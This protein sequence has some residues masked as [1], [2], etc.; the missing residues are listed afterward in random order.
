MPLKESIE[1]KDSS[2][3]LNQKIIKE[4]GIITSHK[5]FKC[6][7]ENKESIDI[8]H[9]DI[10]NPQK[11][12]V[13]S[14][15]DAIGG[16][17]DPRSIPYISKLFNHQDKELRNAVISSAG[18]IENESIKDI[19]IKL[20]KLRH[21][22]DLRIAILNSLSIKYSKDTE[23]NNLIK[24]FVSSTV[25][26]DYTKSQAI[27]LLLKTDPDIELKNL[28]PDIRIGTQLF[29]S[30]L[31]RLDGDNRNAEWII[32]IA[33]QNINRLSVTEKK[34][35]PRI[36]APFKTTNSLRLLVELLMDIDPE[37][38]RSCYEIIGTDSNQSESFG[39]I[40]EFMIDSA[41]PDP[42]LE[43]SARNAILRIGE[44][45]YKN[46]SQRLQGKIGKN[47]EELY[48]TIRESSNRVLSDTHELG[49]YIVHSKEYL[50]Y[51]GNED[52]KQAIVNYL[53]GSG[54]YTQQELLREVKATAVKVEVRHFEG[55]NAILD[56]IK[57]PKRHGIALIARELALA[58][59]G[60]IR[61]MY[62]LIRNLYCTT[63]FNA[64]NMAGEISK[65]YE[66]SRRQ[67]LFRLAEAA[68]YALT[69]IDSKVVF[70]SIKENITPP[71]LSK[72]LAIASL[73]LV[74]H[75]NWSDIED[76]LIRLLEETNESYII[77]NIIDCIYQAPNLKTT[78]KLSILNKFIYEKDS[79]I[80][81]RLAGILELHIDH[82]VLEGL[83]KFYPSSTND[84]K[85]EILKIINHSLKNS[86]IKNEPEITEF[87]YKI[88]RENETWLKG[89]SAGILYILNDD[90]SYKAI[91]KIISENDIENMVSLI[92]AIGNSFRPDLIPTV[93]PIFFLNNPEI[94]TE[95]RTYIDSFDKNAGKE[96]NRIVIDL[97]KRKIDE[98]DLI[99]LKDK[100]KLS[101]PEINFEQEKEKYKF[102]AEHMEKLWIM[103]TDIEDYTRKSQELTSMELNKLIQEYEGIL[104]PIIEKHRGQ[105]IKRIGDGH[106][107]VFKNPLYCVL[108]AIRLQK[109]IKRFNLYREERFRITI[110]VGIHGGDVIYKNNDIFGNSVNLAARLESSA[111]GGKIF[112]S[113]YTYNEVKNYVHSRFVGKLTLKGIEN[114]VPVYEP[115]EIVI[116]LPTNLDPLK[117]RIDDNVESSKIQEIEKK[118][119]ETSTHNPNKY[120]EIN[121]KLIIFIKN[122]LIELN[123]LCMEVEK[124]NSDIKSVERVIKKRW[125]TLKKFLGNL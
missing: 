117:Q 109:A 32:E 71:I 52:L 98:E 43:E 84:K 90:Y 105:L 60:K 96:L 87:L 123:N 35:L 29:Q 75:F 102:E 1:N 7:D 8:L 107:F 86:K 46:L 67:K 4:E 24:T 23:V 108:A 64:K 66:W 37:V 120:K 16:L 112:I 92:N 31:E 78:S 93:T 76:T 110:R 88:M 17:A 34:L 53:K 42:N 83:M 2:T 59:P 81:T 94:H 118:V 9:E 58:K 63:F 62:R 50:E 11:E 25:I 99:P 122:S 113:D 77:H 48:K 82:N 111:R 54:N 55:Y 61:I 115:Y 36:A 68:L 47:I 5:I 38:R 22:E 41:E 30:I 26:S 28:L 121:K 12:V 116:D 19:L 85:R 51:Y 79:E 3:L 33:L 95:L 27:E 49:W 21:D 13:L 56:I 80:T 10:F 65:I 57:N 125:N 114:P 73:R 44:K 89:Y 6:F 14:A 39:K 18:K 70:N 124:G 15:L 45:K 74:N 20:F 100:E 119:K 106:L 69:N 40:I 104:I 103:F 91:Q 97:R 101:S 72:I